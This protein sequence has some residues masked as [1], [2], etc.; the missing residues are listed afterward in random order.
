MT[1]S[2]ICRV[3]ACALA[4]GATIVPARASANPTKQECIDAINDGQDLRQAHK[5]VEAKT[6]F[7]VCIASSCPASLRDD[8][9]KRLADTTAAVP[10]LV[11]EVTDA[12]GNDLASVRV[13]MD[14]KP[15]VETL[16]GSAVEVDPGQHQ[17]SFEDDAGV[18]RRAQRTLIVAEGDRDRHVHI[19]IA[20]D[21]NVSGPE[22]KHATSDHDQRT[23]GWV[24]G[25]VGVGG[26]A[27]GSI[28]GA[29]ALSGGPCNSSDHTCATQGQKDTLSAY[30]VVST[31]GFIAGVAG[32]GVG[33]YLVLTA[34]DDGATARPIAVYP[35][36]SIDSAGIGGVFQ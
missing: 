15:L 29:I 11:F 4:L 19:V 6:R 32:L 17:F 9:G 34:T 2:S 25:S 18:V 5:V 36:L 26:I 16:T 23:I 8:C 35:W 1:R 3:F 28:F 12:R 21:H 22:E 33:A 31:L 27:I 13:A 20:P 14:G 10:T 30:E 24:L 7:A